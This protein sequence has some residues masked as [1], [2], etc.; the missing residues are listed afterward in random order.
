[1]KKRNMLVALLLCV[2]MLLVGCAAPTEVV[3][4]E[5]A[6]APT[7]EPAKEP[8]VIVETVIEKVEDPQITILYTN[9]IHCGINDNLGFAT[10]ATIKGALEAAGRNV[11]LVDNGDAVQG[12]TIGTL[13]KGEYIVDIMNQVGYDVAIP[14]NHEFDYGMDQFNKL[15]EQANYTYISCNFTGPNGVVLPAYKIIE[16]AGKKI[17][18]VGISTPKTLTSSTPKFFMNDAGEFVYNF[19]EDATNDKLVATVQAAIDAARAEGADYVIALSH[20]GIDMSCTPYTSSEVIVKLN[21]L[22]AVLDGHSHSTIPQELVK[23]ADGKDVLLSST[24]TKLSSVG[25]LNITL[26][27]LNSTLITDKDMTA[28]IGDITGQFEE[29]LN[30]VVAN[31]Q[32]ELCIKDPATGERMV[33]SNETNLGDLCADAYLAL[34]DADIAFVNGGGVRDT[35]PAGD[36]NYG[37]IIKVHPYGNMLTVIVAKGQQIKDALE[38]GVR[39]MPGESGGFLQCAGLKYTIDLNVDSHVVLDDKGMFSKVDGDYRVKDIM[40][41]NANGEYEALDLEKEYKLASH[42]YMLLD[43]G[44]G[45]A[46]FDGC[47]VLQD[48]VM[49]DNQVLIN[50]IV[51]YLGGVVGE[52]YADPYGQGRIT[53]I[54]KN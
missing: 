50:Y 4:D 20:L 40:V 17:A 37:Q 13:S 16:K 10:V 46:M 32:Y 36:I 39:N 35:I 6:Q 12:D 29:L 15:V 25:C 21:G 48:S 2:A 28:Y 41:L 54:E 8:E 11:I 5:P 3:V 9:D 45:Y 47:E 53:I 18:F 43:K 30:K 51:D 33:H 27:G 38:H 34:S 49:L 1:M 26:D 24:G 42:N 52:A 19:C 7:A 22:D 31:T 14:G 23:G 44:D